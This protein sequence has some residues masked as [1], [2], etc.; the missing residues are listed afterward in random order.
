MKRKVAG[1]I[2]TVLTT[3]SILGTAM[4]PV[5]AISPGDAIGIA[6]GGAAFGILINN[7]LRA[8]HD[9][10]VYQPP[11]AEYDRGFRDGEERLHYD[12]PRDS[13][14]Y[15]RGYEEGMRRSHYWHDEKRDDDHRD[16]GY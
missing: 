13:L 9:R 4:Q 10:Y 2:T 5:K 7:Q 14:A 6:A 1:V 15:D 11:A 16:Y 12:N 8:N 3:T